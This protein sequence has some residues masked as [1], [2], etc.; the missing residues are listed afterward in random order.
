MLGVRLLERTTRRVTVT[1]EGHAYYARIVDILQNLQEANEDVRE[2]TASFK[3]RV[4]LAAPRHLVSAL[5]VPALPGFLSKHP[6]LEL[7]FI[8]GDARV[9]MIA[10]GVDIAIRINP[11]QD[12]GLIVRRIGLFPPVT[13][14]S[15][16]YL[17]SSSLPR[18]PRNL[19]G[20]ERIAY[21]FPG[22]R[23]GY[24]WVFDCG[25][26]PVEVLQSGRV[27]FDD[28]D[29]YIDA[30]VAGLGLIQV[31]W[32]QAKA[33]I[34]RGELVPVYVGAVAPNIPISILIPE[35]RLQ[36]RRVRCVLS[37]VHDV[38]AAAQSQVDEHL[39]QWRT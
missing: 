30:G 7:D 36:P 1:T 19:S 8:L 26:E 27:W 23:S 9:D 34:D 28:L 24:P 25:G 13:C 33:A 39:A 3:G 2:E 38:V 4:R 12:S 29:A 6:E 17:A 15:P 37:W 22:R 11:T 21:R 16:D 20:K 35:R 32:F 14:A 18:D 31:L 10:D 5:L